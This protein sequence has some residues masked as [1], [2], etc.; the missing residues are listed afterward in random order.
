MKRKTKMEKGI[1]LIALLVTVAVLTILVAVAISGVEN[2]GIIA[3][4]KQSASEFE[5]AQEKEN[6]QRVLLGWSI[7]ETEDLADYLKNKYG[8]DKVQAN[9]GESITIEVES[10]NRYI[11]TEDGAVTLLEGTVEEPELDIQIALDKTSITRE[12]ESGST[13]TETLTATL[14]NATGELIWTSS[15][16]SVATVSGNEGTGIVTLKA[17]G[18]A[19]ITVSYGNVSTTCEVI[20]TEVEAVS[21]IEF[22]ISGTTYY[23]EE[24]MTWEEWINSTEYDSGIMSIYS[25]GAKTFVDYSGGCVSNGSSPVSAKD[26]IIGGNTYRLSP[27]PM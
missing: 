11:V 13:A 22:T 10:G 27:M 16:T 4:T 24:G 20:V 23:A 1:T 17:A 15:N 21:I 7:T 19:T 2:E 18:S 26:E 8:E 5:I 14:T 3:K 6:L 12:I 25:S 9:V